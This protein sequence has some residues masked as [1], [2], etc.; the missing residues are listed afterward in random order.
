[1]NMTVYSQSEVEQQLTKVLDQARRE[2]EVRI[3]TDLGEEFVV[4][5]AGRGRSPLDVGGVDLKVTSDQI[6]AAVRES[7]ER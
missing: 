4:R 5:P 7:R 3:Q 6:V 2:G 1:M